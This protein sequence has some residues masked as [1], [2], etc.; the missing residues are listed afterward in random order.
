MN[1]K[2]LYLGDTALDNAA[3]YLAAVMLH[4]DIAFDYI[5]SAS[6]CSDRQL[7]ED[8]SALVI[9]DYPASNFSQPQF[10]QIIAKTRAGMGLLMIGG[11]E[12]FTGSCGGYQSAP[13]AQLL[14]V[15][16]KAT[17]DRINSFSPCLIRPE[18]EH[19]VTAGLPFATHS[20]AINGY[21]QFRGK[22]NAT[23]ILSVKRYR[24]ALVNGDFE[25]SLESLDPLL[26]VGQAGEGRVACYAGDVAPHWAGGFVDWGDRRLTLQAPG[27]GEV[28]I[29]N[30]YIQ[31][32]GNLIKWVSRNV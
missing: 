1:S 28:E 22:E 2:I 21:N 15:E 12:S 11:W 10:Q 29:G 32:F 20:A 17:D 7:S 30:W 31:F 8:C 4:C 25:F 6:P 18:V 19:P 3:S 14:P 16:M 23:T 13:L 5:D 27:A 24:A 26:V 9:S